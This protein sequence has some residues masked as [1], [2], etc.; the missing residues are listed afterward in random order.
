LGRIFLFE[1]QQNIG[2]VGGIISL[3]LPVPA[4]KHPMPTLNTPYGSLYYAEF[5]SALDNKPPLVL[6][7]GAGADHL[8]W[9]AEI[10]RLAGWR[11]L[12]LDLP[13]HGRSSGAGQSQ[14]VAY[15][16]AVV[17]FLDALKIERAILLGHSMGGA[18]AQTLALHFPQRVAGLVLIGTGAKLSV[19]QEFLA[20]A[21]TDLEQMAMLYVKWAYSSGGNDNLKRLGKRQM[22]ATGGSVVD[23]DY[24]ACHA[25]D[26]QT[27]LGAI[28]A[29]TLIIGA[30]QDKMTPFG[31]SEA[32][33]KGIGRSK[34]AKVEGA[35]HMMLIEKPAEVANIIAD[36]LALFRG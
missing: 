20:L 26:V 11:I 27:Q 13:G 33:A 6:I 3:K 35:G 18:I 31:L 34:L 7:H 14:I 30:D 15:A 19:N 1:L 2:T 16:H 24:R 28:H 10:R 5:K 23:G 25:F 4:P 8:V 21:L 17:A 32:L 12:A 36:W 22:L 9:P 29:P